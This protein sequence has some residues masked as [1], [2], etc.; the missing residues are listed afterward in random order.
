MY[1]KVSSRKHTEGSE[2][3]SNFSM[4]WLLKKKSLVMNVRQGDINEQRNKESIWVGL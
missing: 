2:G 3:I 4:T 1:T